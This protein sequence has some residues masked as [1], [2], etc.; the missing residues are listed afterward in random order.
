MVIPTHAV[1]VDNVR[2]HSQERCYQDYYG[3][4]D[5]VVCSDGGASD[6]GVGM[7]IVDNED[8]DGVGG[9]HNN[10]GD[11]DDSDHNKDRDD[12]DGGGD[13]DFS[14]D[15]GDDDDDDF[16]GARDSEVGDAHRCLCGRLP[17]LQPS[18]DVVA[19]LNQNLLSPP[20]L[21]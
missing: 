10:D 12:E 18:S 21:C 17:S 19:S 20:H 14:N 13:G 16:G 6:S 2:Q 15:D 5:D 4:G 7:A 3:D 9:D 11:E 1:Q 8:D